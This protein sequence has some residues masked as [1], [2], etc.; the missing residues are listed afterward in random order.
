MAAFAH[1]PARLIG[2][3]HEL[4]PNPSQRVE[5]ALPLRRPRT[6][7]KSPSCTGRIKGFS[8][9]VAIAPE[10]QIKRERSVSPVDASVLSIKTASK[11]VNGR[12]HFDW[13]E[14][15]TPSHA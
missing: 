14:R 6:V 10:K 3:F 7:L 13:V 11:P 15:I 12:V 9:F 5:T 2:T 8:R 1:E 4:S